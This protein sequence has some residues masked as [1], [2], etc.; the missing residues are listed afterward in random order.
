[1]NTRIQVEHP[2]TEM[3]TGLDLVALQIRLA[4]GDDLSSLTQ[5]SIRPCGHSIECRLY[6]E[7]P[8]W[9]SCRRPDG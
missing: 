8:R 9:T 3:T 1:M 4:R 2:V 6:A 7:I 5:E